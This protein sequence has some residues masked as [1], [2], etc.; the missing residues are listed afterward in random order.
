MKSTTSPLP[1]SLGQVML[2]LEG[3]QLTEADRRRLC[4]PLV[5]GVI[6]F[7]RNYESPRQLEELTTEIR[8]LR[9]PPLLI[10]VD[11][12]GRARPAGACSGFVTASRDCH[13]CAPWVRCG[14]NTRSGRGISP[15]IP[16]TFWLPNCAPT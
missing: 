7:S 3:K 13:R 6:L 5:G 2:D 10:A 16:G 9:S 4:H 14:T 15:G 8:R 11:H 12:E 1:A